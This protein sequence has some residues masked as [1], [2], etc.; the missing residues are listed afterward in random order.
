MQA[1]LKNPM[2]RNYATHYPYPLSLAPMQEAAKDLVGTHDFTG[3]TASGTSVENKVRTITQ[4]R[5]S[6]DEKLD[7]MSLLFLAMVFF[8]SKL[9]TWSEHC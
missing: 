6:I 5:V 1:V 9:E 7:S 2:M 8:I 3:F 4:A